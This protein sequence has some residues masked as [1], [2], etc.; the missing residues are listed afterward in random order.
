MGL[1]LVD[2]TELMDLNTYR[3][4]ENLNTLS[5][6]QHLSAYFTSIVI[7]FAEDVEMELMTKYESA[8]SFGA[9]EQAEIDPSTTLVLH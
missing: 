9:G 1:G 6:V 7:S 4:I 3:P 2:D 5:L 8:M